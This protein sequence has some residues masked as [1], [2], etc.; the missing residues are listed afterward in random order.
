MNFFP[1]KTALAPAG[2]SKVSA[3]METG[4]Y[5]ALNFIRRSAKISGCMR[6][7]DI[8]ERGGENTSEIQIYIAQTRHLENR[9][10]Q[11]SRPCATTSLPES[12]FSDY[13]RTLDG[14][15]KGYG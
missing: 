8:S 14:S 5:F 4:D 6:S 7:P 1:R 2:R 12:R 13:H 10:G 3:M 15:F 11:N 9:D